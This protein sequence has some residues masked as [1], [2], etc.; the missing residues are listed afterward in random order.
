MDSERVFYTVIGIIFII[1]FLFACL[2]I[3]L[4]F[5]VDLLTNSKEKEEKS[6]TS[7]FSVCFY[8][9][10][11]DPRTNE[12][13]GDTVTEFTGF[14]DKEKAYEFFRRNYSSS[15]CHYYVIHEKIKID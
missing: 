3:T 1:F 5:L 14:K 4:G 15:K 9:I 10:V 8:K 2:S 12:I 11:E 6:E 7:S 13:I